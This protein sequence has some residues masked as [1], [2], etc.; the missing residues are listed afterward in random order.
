GATLRHDEKVAILKTCVKAVG[1]EVPVVAGI[2]A[3]STAESEQLAREAQAA[4]CSGLM[5][6]PAYVYKGDWRETSAH[7]DAVFKATPLSCMLYN[8]PIAYAV[9]VLPEQ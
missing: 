1:D 5:V 6:L 4:G 8:N 3:L 2:S 9:D 7:F